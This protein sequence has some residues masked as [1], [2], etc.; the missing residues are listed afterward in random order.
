MR[1]R[2]PLHRSDRICACQSPCAG[3]RRCPPHCPCTGHPRARRDLW[4][5]SAYCPKQS[6]S[7]G[8]LPQE[9]QGL[10]RWFASTL[11]P[12]FL[13]K[14][15]PRLHC[16]EFQGGRPWSC[17]QSISSFWSRLADT[18]HPQA[19]ILP[20]PHPA[21]AGLH[22]QRFPV[23]HGV[24]QHFTGTTGERHANANFEADSR[25]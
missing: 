17:S 1:S 19:S 20:L 3:S 16:R 18:W 21:R 6:V 23:H 13:R 10:C 25:R 4:N 24:K 5:P 8:F 12:S 11:G 14:H 7:P 15:C 9:I 2:A 22:G